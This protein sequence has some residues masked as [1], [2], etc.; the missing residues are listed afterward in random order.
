[1]KYLYIL[2][3]FVLIYSCKTDKATSNNINPY[4]EGLFVNELDMELMTKLNNGKILGIPNVLIIKLMND[5]Q[6]LKISEVVDKTNFNKSVQNIYDKIIDDKD[7]IEN[8]RK[9]LW[10][11][12][13]TYNIY[14]NDSIIFTEISDNYIIKYNGKIINDVME[15]R[16]N[17]TLPDSVKDVYKPSYDKNAPKEKFVFYPVKM[18]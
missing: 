18:K 15:L 13:L 16:A 14:N 6:A 3:A 11:S 10:I 2:T 12:D 7:Y 1:M 5:K 4:Y 8:R 17:V 9:Q